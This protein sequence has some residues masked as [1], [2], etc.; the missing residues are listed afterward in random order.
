V[1]NYSIF[2]DCRKGCDWS[3]IRRERDLGSR[4]YKNLNFENMKKESNL[5]FLH[6]WNMIVFS[7]KGK[8]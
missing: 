2:E 8:K 7:C 3:R 5:L 1:N 6:V 4:R